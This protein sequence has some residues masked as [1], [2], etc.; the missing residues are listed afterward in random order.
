MANFH[1]ILVNIIASDCAPSQ[2]SI[3]S[4]LSSVQSL[5]H[6]R[7][8]DPMDIRLPYPSPTPRA[9]SNSCPSSWWCH[10]TI[11]SSVIPFSSCPQSFPPPI[12]W[13]PDVKNWLIGKDPD[14]GKGKMSPLGLWI[15]G[16]LAFLL[17]SSPP[18]LPVFER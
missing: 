7:L 10:P 14:A 13:R 6:V 12:L 8:C 16:C 17:L 4:P 3:M 18:P 11:S 15:S 1:Y 5:S 9:C 2:I